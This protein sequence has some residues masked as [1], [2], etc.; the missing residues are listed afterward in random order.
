MKLRNIF[1]DLFSVCS[2]SQAFITLLKEAWPLYFNLHF[3][4]WVC[5]CVNPLHCYSP[6]SSDEGF[7]AALPSRNKRSKCVICHR[8]ETLWCV[9]RQ[10]QAR[11]FHVTL[12]GRA[13]S[14]APAGT[15]T[16][17]SVGVSA[18]AGRQPSPCVS[19][20]GSG[21]RLSGS[22]EVFGRLCISL[23]VLLRQKC[24][25]S[26]LLTL[27]R[28]FQSLSKMC[29]GSF[30]APKFEEKQKWEQNVGFLL[31]PVAQEIL[32]ATLL[33]SWLRG[34]CLAGCRRALTSH[35][36]ALFCWFYWAGSATAEWTQNHSSELIT[37]TSAQVWRSS[38][39]CTCYMYICMLARSC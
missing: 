16:V 29:L 19:L 22:G 25:R 28:K 1:P 12:K 39:S 17:S 31:S 9:A 8:S 37:W 4:F 36:R 5:W 24:W 10:S 30:E 26:A 33:P 34:K 23:D 21:A 7:L 3:L 2:D 18:R 32:E 11:C 38:R 27:I 35:L 6:R 13:P 14:E 20:I 15:A